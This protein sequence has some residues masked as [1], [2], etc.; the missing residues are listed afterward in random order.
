MS[1]L[2]GT[3]V[4]DPNFP[5]IINEKNNELK[6]TIE[7][8]DGTTDKIELTIPSGY[9]SRN[10]M[11]DTLNQKLAGTGITAS[12]YGDYSIQLGGDTGFITG[13]KGNMFRIEDTNEQVMISVFYDNTKYGTHLF[14]R[15]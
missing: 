8:F 7:N 11:I 6:F 2:I 4:F 12:E 13:L 10:K 14:T 15:N 1:S 3:T 5:L 9:Y